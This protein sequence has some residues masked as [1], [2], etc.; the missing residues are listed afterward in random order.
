MEEEDRFPL[1]A[2]YAVLL[3]LGAA[4]GIW[5]AFLVPLRLP[6]GVEGLSDV[7]AF[8][9]N[10][11]VGF[12]AARGARSVPAAAMPGIGWLVAVLAVGTFVR[13]A[14][15]VVIPSKLGTDPGIGTVGNLFLVLGAVGAVVAILI[16][17]R[18]R[19]HWPDQSG[20]N[21]ANRT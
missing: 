2:V 13:P 16:A 15:E 20:T 17:N 11:A 14:D 4:L 3:L 8:V 12:L 10:V 5:G 7:L 19:L 18:D 6:G 21:A 9:G 1:A